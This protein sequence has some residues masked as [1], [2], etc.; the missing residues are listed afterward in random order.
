MV[1]AA[2]MNNNSCKWA[3]FGCVWAGVYN[4]TAFRGLDYVLHQASLN[5]VR[6][7]FTLADNWKTQDSKQN[8]RGAPARPERPA[9][10]PAHREHRSAMRVRRR[11]C[12]ASASRRGARAPLMEK[13]YPNP[14]NEAGRARSIY[15]GRARPTWT[16]SGGAPPSWSSSS[17][18]STR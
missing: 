6:V 2:G 1:Y 18:T 9:R 4:E 3:N 15:T 8:V 12:A 13:P 16:R 11:A 5:G 10:R 7:L 17:A 14:T